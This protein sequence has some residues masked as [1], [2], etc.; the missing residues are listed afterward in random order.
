MFQYGD[1]IMKFYSKFISFIVK[2]YIKELF[3]Y[4][5][6]NIRYVGCLY[7]RP[8]VIFLGF[9]FVGLPDSQR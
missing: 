5:S 6:G 3:K 9:L 8:Q 2:L 4:I 7:P 1:S